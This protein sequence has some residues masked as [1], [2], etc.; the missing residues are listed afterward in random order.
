MFR[1]GKI[2]TCSMTVNKYN[3]S[4]HRSITMKPI[5]VKKYNN[6]Y[7]RSIMIKPIEVNKCNEPLA[8]TNL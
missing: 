8:W 1:L 7:H 5:E 2:L 6:S 4:Y 3:S